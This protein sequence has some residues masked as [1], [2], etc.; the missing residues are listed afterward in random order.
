[1]RSIKIA[2]TKLCCGFDVCKEKSERKIVS[3]SKID[4]LIVF[5]K[6]ELPEFINNAIDKDDLFIVV[7]GRYATL[8]NMVCY[9]I[10]IRGILSSGIDMMGLTQR[11]Y[12]DR[13]LGVPFPQWEKL[14]A[15]THD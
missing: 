1:M 7:G 8:A 6:A 3:D 9:G 10:P 12:Y 14:Y 11:I 4:E 15:E 2:T 5:V 13:F